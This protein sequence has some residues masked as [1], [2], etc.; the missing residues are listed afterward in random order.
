MPDI[1]VQLPSRGFSVSFPEDAT[2]EEIQSILDRDYPRNGQDVVYAL[3]EDPSFAQKISTED[4]ALY[5]QFMEDRKVDF[6]QAAATGAGVIGTT[7]AKGV[8]GLFDL[9]NLNPVSA[10]A[11][12]V[13]SGAQGTRELYGMLA[14]SEDPSSIMFRFKDWINGTGTAQERKRQWL[15][16]R[17][18]ADR[19]RQLTEGQTTVTGIDPA[20]VNNDVKNMVSLIADPTLLIPGLGEVFGAGRLATRAVGLGAEAAGR[21]AQVVTKPL[22]AGIEAGTRLAADAFGAEARTLRGVAA[23]TGISGAVM[24]LPG[25]A[26]AVG[27]VGAIEGADIA[28]EVLQRAGQQLANAPTR[29]GPLEALMLNPNATVIDKALA[30]VGRYGGD[31]LIDIGLRSG[32]GAIEGAAIGAGLG[33]LSAGEEGAATGLGSGAVLGATGAGAVRTYDMASGKAAAQARAADYGRFRENLSD[34]DGA[35]WDKVAN[36]DGVDAAVGLMDML[37]AARTKYNQVDTIVTDAKGMAEAGLGTTRGAALI[38]AGSSRPRIYINADSTRPDLTAAH[39]LF[40]IFEKVEQTAPKT[41]ALRQEITGT[42]LVTPDGKIN[43]VRPGLLK[44]DQ[45]EAAHQQYIKG[46]EKS[47]VTG[48]DLDV[49][50]NAKTIDQKASVVGRELGAEYMLKLLRG[51]DPDAML[52]G[53]DGI[54]RTLLDYSLMRNADGVLRGMAEKFGLGTKPAE[55]LLFDKLPNASPQVNAMLRD[56]VRSY[57]NLNERIEVAG[58]SGGA[59]FN[60]KA[61]ANP[62]AASVAVKAGVAE[63]RPDGTT[64][65]LS[66]DELEQRDVQEGK[67]LADIV[68]NTPIG[69]STKPYL[70]IVDDKVVGNGISP[71][72]IEAIA[73]SPRIS[74]KLRENILAFDQ[75]LRAKDTPNEA[76][77]V[78]IE[79][80]PALT[81]KKDRFTGI[82]KSV[83]S[84]GIR[85]TQ[86]KVAP[87]RLEFNKGD[88]PYVFAVDVTKLMDRAADKAMAGKL[89]AYG[90]DFDGFVSDIVRYFE[91]ISDPAGKR[92]AD[93][94]G[95]TS[96]KASFLNEF[97]GSSEKGGAEF[98][99]SFRLDRIT[100]LRQTG[101]RI[102][103]SELAFQRH[104]ISWMPAEK[105]GDGQV[106]QSPDG[107]R[108]IGNGTN[109]HLYGPDGERIGIYETQAKAEAKAEKE[110]NTNLSLGQWKKRVG[111][112]DRKAIIEAEK[113]IAEVAKDNPEAIR[114]EIQ[115]DKSGKPKIKL[116]EDAEGNPILDDNGKQERGVVFKK[117]RYSLRDAPGLSKDDASAVKQGSD[118]LEGSAREALRNADIKAGLGWYAR[119]RNFFQE[120][121]GA[122]IE[123][124]GQLLGATSARTPVDTNFKQAL[125]ALKLFSSGVYDDLVQK[126][127][128]HVTRVKANAASGELYADW[129]AANPSKRDSEFVL[130]DEMRKQI[131]DFDEVPLRSNGA[132]FNANSMKV[133]QVLY[134]NWIDQTL[135]PKTPNFAGNLTGRTLA[136]T[137]DVWAARNLRRLL[138]DGKRAKWRILPEQESGVDYTLNKKGVYG[139]DF[140]FAQNI[141]AE[142]GKRMG[143]SPD[144]LQ[145]LMWFA[146]K[147]VW[148]KNGWT[149]KA[150]GEKSSFDKEAG[151]LNMRRYQAGV[152]TFKDVETFSAERQ[153]TAAKEIRDAING[154]RVDRFKRGKIEPGS[155]VARVTHTE[156]LY[157]GKT[158]PSLDVEF[159]V[160]RATSPMPVL[161]KIIEIASRPENI[162]DDVFLSK[163]V[164]KNHVNARPGVEVGFSQPAT[165]AQMKAI[166]DVFRANGIDGFT[167]ARDANG[168]AIGIRTQYIPEISGVNDAAH[169]DPNNFLANVRIWSSNARAANK[170]L[171]TEIISYAKETYFSTH[172]V[173]REEYARKFSSDL[174]GADVRAELGRR[175]QVLALG[176]RKVPGGVGAEQST[177]AGGFQTASRANEGPGQSTASVN[178]QP[179]A[180][181][182][183]PKAS[184]PGWAKALQIYSDKSAGYSPSQG[185][186]TGLT[187]SLRSGA[188]Q[189][190]WEDMTQA[191][192]IAEFRAAAIKD[193]GIAIKEASNP[194]D[195]LL[196]RALDPLDPMS[197]F[198]KLVLDRAGA[199]IKGDKIRIPDSV[200]TQIDG[201]SS[202]NTLRSFQPAAPVESATNIRFQPAEQLPNG[203]VWR[204]QSG[205]SIIQKDGGNFRV[206]S[207]LGLIGVA[208]SYEKAERLANKR[209]R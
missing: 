38:D 43:L 94:P 51:S 170:A 65:L 67:A 208:S 132:K 181:V 201:R 37:A 185:Q 205:F 178:F 69:D 156:G 122:N 177:V 125:E 198:Y 108:I 124:F 133:L 118:L 147:H 155:I 88:M 54:T 134:G 172:V 58:R 100:E 194:T 160:Q 199:E 153:A 126:Y 204:G 31:A 164:A 57:R 87:Y 35:L 123:T 27:V 200:R 120:Q 111:P 14:Q 53:F 169:L 112:E 175:Q 22:T 143:I 127:H 109:W 24:G 184:D 18:F 203:K 195:Y 61:L 34:S 70:R 141:Y 121:F 129:K 44:P 85:I 131:N 135:G 48:P 145:A 36:R 64:R 93:L 158:E 10:G 56:L 138:Y 130:T 103:S 150:G 207:P 74:N 39:E 42:Y 40:H 19:T 84:S 192:R 165:E 47:G 202:P 197:G 13:E 89:G 55:S 5:E 161:R 113:R 98:I 59:V 167:V 142:V 171:P 99:R 49:W 187:R 29:I 79:Y 78:W 209:A 28:A 23:G 166:M 136:A 30:K 191:E 189:K 73:N 140:V 62:A 81:R 180:L 92:T 110:A 76:N 97:F 46:L 174:L 66:Q 17:D 96:E 6:V 116:L 25:A 2:P 3:N 179:D 188:G 71:E 16:A 63:T 50:K 12:A 162:Q 7:I 102:A 106:V 83:Y 1:V 152:T 168:N 90:R 11:T 137:I 206:Y 52:R 176:Q 139:G 148:D 154:L 144:D 151:K 33:Y 15:E 104:K 4:Y 91:N 20:L 115:R 45:V 75:S 82:W 159:S 77:V 183:I 9:Q 26:T 149:N 68:G 117:V 146:E 95:M 105:V 86:R 114:L 80:A 8:R 193:Y 173:G 128:N 32:A 186:T 196:D 190:L 41:E 182:A 101:E 72:Q 163:I 157:G 119:M 21:A 60:R 107:Y